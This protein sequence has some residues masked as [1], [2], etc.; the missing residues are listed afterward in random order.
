MRDRGRAWRELVNR[1]SKVNPLHWLDHLRNYEYLSIAMQALCS[2]AMNW[3]R[4]DN[5][6]FP[7][8]HRTSVC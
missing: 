4:Y 8:M 5:A 6:T 2:C 1:L 3:R 7:Y